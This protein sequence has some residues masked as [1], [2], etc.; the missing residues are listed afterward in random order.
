MENGVVDEITK[1][2]INECIKKI[3]KSQRIKND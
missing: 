2:W 1:K 3:K